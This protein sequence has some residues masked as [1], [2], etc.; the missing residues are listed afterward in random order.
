MMTIKKK[1]EVIL[2]M[3]LF[4][5]SVFTYAQDNTAIK[6]R[7]TDT[8]G[9]PISNVVVS[10]LD[11]FT[12][13]SS[14]ISGNFSIPSAPEKV[15][16]FSKIGYQQQK[17]EIKDRTEINI[18]LEKQTSEEFYPVAYGTRTK[19]TLTSAISTISADDLSKAP[20]STLGNAIQGLASGLTLVR[21]VGA[22]PGWDQPTIYIRGVQS[23]G[24]GVAPL[25][26]V[27]NVERDYSQ[28]DPEEIE[29]F[30][31]LKDA[32]ATAMYGMRGANGVILVT[33]KKGFIGKP[34]I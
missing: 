29:S 23:F 27:D 8:S 16:L 13:V 30:T 5:F 4:L 17:Y 20:V 12:Q 1:P 34:V 6:G 10:V 25:V 14:D 18:Q 32:A 33:T 2:I 15:I 19:S 24:G 21:T 9:N 7:I 26:L 28:L 3:L 31:V 11:E 22:E